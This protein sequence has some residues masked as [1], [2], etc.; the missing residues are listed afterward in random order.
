M[1]GDL[2]N[3]DFLK[4]ELLSQYLFLCVGFI[5]FALAAIITL[6]ASTLIAAKNVHQNML[7]AVVAAPRR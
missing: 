3:G 6:E 2:L 4:G 7:M 1:D 5:L